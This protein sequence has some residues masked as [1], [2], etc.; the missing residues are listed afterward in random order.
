M[1]KTLI[2]RGRHS[3]CFDRGQKIFWAEAAQCL[4]CSEEILSRV[5][6]LEHSEQ[7]D[8]WNGKPP[9]QVLSGMPAVLTKAKPQQIVQYCRV[10]RSQ[11]KAHWLLKTRARREKIKD[12]GTIYIGDLLRLDEKTTALRIV[13]S[14]KSL[15][16]PLVRRGTLAALRT[17]DP[18]FLI[19]LGKARES[20]T[21]CQ[22]EDWTRCDQ[23]DSFLVNNWCG[24]SH[25]PWLPPLCF[26]TDA[27]LAELCNDALG[28]KQGSSQE[29][30]MGT[31]RKRRQ[32]LCLEQP[33]QPRITRLILKG[34]TILLS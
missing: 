26:F 24:D 25:C 3:L 22:L 9:V 23:L 27:V 20:K 2:Q 6:D 31:M 19:R 1:S 11:L 21:R 28:R 34:D 12:T 5:E 8:F 17:D 7:E 15:N 4:F 30:S 13:E 29:I 18:G 16:D 33:A 32:R 10:R 14:S